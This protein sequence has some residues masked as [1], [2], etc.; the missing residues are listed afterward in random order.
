VGDFQVEARQVVLAGSQ[1]SKGRRRVH[2]ASIMP[3]AFSRLKA[4][5]VQN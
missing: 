5:E 4:A 1:D 2:D 3:V